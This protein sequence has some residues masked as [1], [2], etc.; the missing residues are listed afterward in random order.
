MRFS[1]KH[2][3]IF[4][5]LVGA[6][7]RL[8]NFWNIPFSHDEFSMIFRAGYWN[9][10]DL[11]ELGVKTDTH[12]AGIQVFMNYY[13]LFFGMKEW[14]VKLPF[15]LAG[16]ASIW[17]VFKIGKLWFNESVGLFSAAFFASIQFTIMYAQ[18]ARPYGS[19]VF[20]ALLLVLYW[21][22]IILQPEQKLIKNLIL[23]AVFGALCAYNHHFSLLFAAIV[24]VLGIP[25]VKRQ[26][27]WKYALSG[28]G[29]FLLYTPHLGVF[30]HQLNKGGVGGEGG[31]LGAPENDFILNFL[32]YATHYSIGVVLVVIGIFIFGW[33][34]KSENKKH[35]LRSLLFLSLFV[36]P[37]LIGFFYSRT[38]DGANAILQFSLLI[39]G[40]PFL[41][42]A[43][44]GHIKS[45]NFKT[46]VVLV[47]LIFSANISTL[48]FNRQHYYIYYESYFEE[49]FTQMEKQKAVYP[50]LISVINSDERMT[51]FVVKKHNIQS[52]YFWFKDFE[53]LKEFKKFLQESSK[54]SAHFYFATSLNGSNELIPLIKEFY[55]CVQVK[56]Y[57]H[58]ESYFFSK[59][60][61]LGNS[62]VLSKQRFQ[63]KN[64]KNWNQLT[65]KLDSTVEFGPQFST[66]IQP[67]LTHENNWI[68]ISCKVKPN[69]VLTDK[70]VLTASLEKNGELLNWSGRSIKDFSLDSTDWTTGYLSLRLADMNFDLMRDTSVQLNVQVWNSGKENYL[71][72]YI[73]IE[74]RNGNPFVYSWFEEIIPILVPK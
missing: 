47:L 53:N 35:W 36:I 15:I 64:N 39:F 42:L 11:I 23:F 58:G 1:N 2:L 34:K 38:D 74:R 49:F 3:L 60:G 51:D 10:N 66:K 31:W 13:M 17:L 59:K 16:I 20:F 40:F 68:D 50:N 33:F 65:A 4:I 12:P 56:R 52:E 62:F 18:M 27:L 29:I 21:S 72:D 45:L 43:F 32:D 24:G 55:P 67:L 70:L 46:N 69:F 7:L 37:F 19:G 48:I 61:K 41:L 63:S 14:V 28:T 73:T 57:T 5:L 8:Y 44:F 6:T 30:F 71:I 25:L 22:K 26:F 54:K 9:F